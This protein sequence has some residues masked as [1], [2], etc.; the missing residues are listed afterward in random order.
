MGGVAEE[1]CLQALTRRRDFSGRRSRPR[2]SH[3]L[4]RA[5]LDS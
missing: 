1:N 2:S 5:E 3:E 4:N